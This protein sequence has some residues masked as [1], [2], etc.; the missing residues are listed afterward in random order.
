VKICYKKSNSS[1]LLNFGHIPTKYA[2]KIIPNADD[3]EL[4]NTIIRT[5]NI[6]RSLNCIPSV[7]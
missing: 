2:V 3:P 4:I 6:N 5:F 7:I 1:Q